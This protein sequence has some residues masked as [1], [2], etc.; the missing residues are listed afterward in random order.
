MSFVRR[1]CEDASKDKSLKRT[2]FVKRLTPMTRMGKANEKS[3]D[4]VAK[5][6]LGPVFHESGMTWKVS[7]FSGPLVQFTRCYDGCLSSSSST[8]DKFY[9]VL[10]DMM[11]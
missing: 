7:T 11:S 4:E 8:F 6:V 9:I 1:I 5:A 3:L 2:R 10:H